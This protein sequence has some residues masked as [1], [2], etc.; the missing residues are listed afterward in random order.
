MTT[1][2]ELHRGDPL[3][4]PLTLEAG[5]E[6]ED[7]DELWF[8]VR[9]RPPP[10]STVTDA[11]ALAQ[12]TL[13]GGGIVFSSATAGTI[14]ILSAVTTTWPTGRLYWDLQAR[15]VDDG[16]P[17]TLDS[18][19]L[20][21]V[22]DITRSQTVSG[23][24]NKDPDAILDYSIDWSEWL[25]PGEGIASSAWEV[26]GSGLTIGSG[27][28]APTVSGTSTIVWLLGG[29]VGTRYKVTNHITSDSSPARSDDR[30]FY[31]YITQL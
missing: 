10:T 2:A 23:S 3:I 22:A 13:T 21:I 9:R 24:F 4:V 28:Y 27:S 11:D 1:L 16:E 31:V 25:N 5:F 18:G 20:P 8:T 14:T 19:V 15:K 26:S 7:F 6:A 29:T 30:S 17:Y 12:V